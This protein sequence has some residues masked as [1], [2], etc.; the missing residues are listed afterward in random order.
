M[1]YFD[2]GQL[3]N[4]DTK[5]NSVL[6]SRLQIILRPQAEVADWWVVLSS[7]AL[8]EPKDQNKPHARVVHLEATVA[9]TWQSPG[10]A[11]LVGRTLYS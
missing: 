11:T 8:Q 6:Y 4:C 9:T 10:A 7:V 3:G 5:Y 1:L 2:S